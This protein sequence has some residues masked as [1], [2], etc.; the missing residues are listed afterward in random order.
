MLDPNGTPQVPSGETV[1]E[2]GD[3]LV[4]VTRKENAEQLRQAL[5]GETH[6]LDT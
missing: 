1:I 2:P 3:A 5:L 4:M 6:G